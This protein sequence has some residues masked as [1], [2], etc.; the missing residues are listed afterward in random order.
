MWEFLNLLPIIVWTGWSFVVGACVGSLLNVCVAR[1]PLEKSLLWPL[2]SRCGICYQSIRWYDNLP[3]LSYVILRG[4]CRRCGAGFSPRYLLVEFATALVFAGL[5][6][7]EAMLNVR[8]SHFV[9]DN[10]WAI[11]GGMIPASLWVVVLHRWLLASFLIV[12]AAC[13][14]QSREI[15]LSVT[16]TGTIVGLV[17]SAF[18]GWPWPE[19]ASRIPGGATEWWLLL[20]PNTIPTGTQLWPYWGPALDGIPHDSVRCGL[21]TSILGLLCG[22]WLLRGVRFLATRGLGREALGLGDADLMMMVGAFLGWQGVF[23]GFFAG[24]VAA[25]VLAVVSV[26]IFRDDSLP[27]GPGLALGSLGVTLCWPTLSPGLAIL[28]FHPT[29][30]FGIFGVGGVMMFGLCWVMGRIRGPVDEPESP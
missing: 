26:L 4:R 25:L 7:A 6:Y 14:I 9:R 30:L 11:R 2:G 20:P 18:V 28:L 5:F 22:T 1:I 13:D 3:L 10:T 27:F 12:A 21:A 23:A 8:D 24:A 19:P 15:P 29:L 17:F 16:V